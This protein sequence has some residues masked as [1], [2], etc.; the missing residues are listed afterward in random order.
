[1]PETPNLG[2]PLIVAQQAMKHVTHYEGLIR[3]DSL[4]HLSVSQMS[5]VTP[6]ASPKAGDRLLLGANPTGSFAGYAGMLAFYDGSSWRFTSPRAGWLLFNGA[7]KFI[8]VFDGT[9]W[10]NFFENLR[11]LQNLT[12]LGVGTSADSSNRLAVKTNAALFTSLLTSEGGSGD[13]RFT[14]NRESASKTVSQLY[15]T[16]WSG[17]AETGLMGD[18]NWR[19][20]LSSNG[21][22][23]TDALIGYSA[24]GAIRVDQLLSGRSQPGNNGRHEIDFDGGSGSA[25]VI[26]DTSSSASSL[27][28]GFRKAGALVGSIRLAPTGTSFLTTSDYR[29]KANIRELDNALERL[30]TLKPKRF[31]FLAE[32]DRVVDGF[33][34]HE[35]NEAVPEAVFGK[36]DEVDH[37]GN[38]APQTI[39]LSRL[40]PLLVAALLEVTKRLDVLESRPH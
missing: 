25:S 16:N 34:A 28:I 11:S 27:A 20:K 13:L 21:S 39:D 31:S 36:K 5:A 1:M 30:K 32:P 15:Q 17:R 22:T 4:V 3:L 29:L 12:G 37:H 40:V 38:V 35:V 33:L 23:W 18:D 26:T 10:K 24:T 6:P 14:L 9:V 7:D 8:Y 2:L 19:L